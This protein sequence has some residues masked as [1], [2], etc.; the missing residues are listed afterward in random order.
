MFHQECSICIECRASVV[1]P[2]VSSIV[3]VS[4]LKMLLD[5]PGVILAP[6]CPCL[7][8]P[9]HA[10]ACFCLCLLLPAPACLCL[11]L[12]AFACFCL[13]LLAPACLP[14][15]APACPCLPLLACPC[16]P[17]PCLPAPCLPQPRCF[18]VL[19][20]RR[21]SLVLPFI[22]KQPRLPF[23]YSVRIRAYE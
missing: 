12:P 3:Q 23:L 10:F 4:V 13:P 17:A 8:L 18:K 19:R 15:P 6:A 7:S 14:L 20:R 2:L 11:L 21:V 1:L 9:A 22:N 16:L 5:V